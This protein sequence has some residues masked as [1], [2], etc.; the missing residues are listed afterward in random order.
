MTQLDS[1][2]FSLIQFDSAQLAGHICLESNLG[3]FEIP[4]NPKTVLDSPK[5]V[6]S[7]GTMRELLSKNVPAYRGFLHKF[8]NITLSSHSYEATVA[9]WLACSPCNHE[10][11]GSILTWDKYFFF[12]NGSAMGLI[13]YNFDNR[14]L[15]RSFHLAGAL[16]EYFL[17]EIAPLNQ[18]N[19][20][21]LTKMEVYVL[22]AK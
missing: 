20:T 9:E 19:I 8:I 21:F 15:S 16:M 22:G 17:E 11:K 13:I 3:H 12:K 5:Q 2:R 14:S 1:V 6:L 7:D 10:I 18:R 4:K